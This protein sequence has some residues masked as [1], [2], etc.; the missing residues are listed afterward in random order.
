M[1]EKPVPATKEGKAAKVDKVMHEFGSGQ[2]HSGSKE[3]PVVDNPKQA[4]AIALSESGQARNG[5]PH[6]FNRPPSKP[7]HGYGH[8][9]TSGSQRNSGH[10]GAHRIGHRGK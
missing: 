4:V 7:A 1:A 9:D 2:L 8:A 10:P 5:P 6:T 3:G